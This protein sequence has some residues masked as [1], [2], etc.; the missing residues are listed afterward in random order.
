MPL[1]QQ[2]LKHIIL[3]TFPS[4]LKS[5]LTYVL[6]VS[7]LLDDSFQ[8]KM[9]SILQMTNSQLN[10]GGGGGGVTLKDIG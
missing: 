3:F 2:H 7:G 10:G 5:D 8:V 1:L 6:C 4:E 9:H